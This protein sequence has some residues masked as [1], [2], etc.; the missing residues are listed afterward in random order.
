MVEQRTGVVRTTISIPQ[1][2]KDQMDT[3][4]EQANWSA[5]ATGAFEEK[6]GQIAAQKIEKSMEDV[7]QRLRASKRETE[8]RYTNEGLKAGKEWAINDASWS[9]LRDVG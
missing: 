3:V 7:I 6:L 8:T 5:V 2:I 9:S 4:K 1:D